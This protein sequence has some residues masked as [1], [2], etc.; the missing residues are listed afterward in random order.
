[1]VRRSGA[2][3]RGKRRPRRCVT[4]AFSFAMPL[5]FD[6]SAK[7]D[8]NIDAAARHLVENILRHDDIFA[9]K[10]RERQKLGATVQPGGAANQRSGCC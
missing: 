6:T 3:D 9:E 7:L 5:R 4:S 8:H 1:M 2:L 10:R